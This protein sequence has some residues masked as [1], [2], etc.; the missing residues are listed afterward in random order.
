MTRRDFVTMAGAAAA[1]LAGRQ[2][3]AGRPTRP[4]IVVFFT[5]QQRWDTC[6]CYRANPMRLTPNLDRMAARGTLLRNSFTCQPVCA[7]A[8][9]SFQTGLYAT[10]HGVWRNGIPL[11]PGSPTLATR[12]KEAGYTTGYIGKWHLA[13][14]E[15]GPVPVEERGGYDYWL[16][17][18]VLE[19]T[20]HPNDFRTWTGDNKEYHRPGYR[21]DA[22][23]DCMLDFLK[24]RAQAPGQPFFLFSSFLEPHHQ[25]DMNHF[26][27]PTGYAEKYGNRM[28]VPPDLREAGKGDWPAE[29]PD[30]YGMVA[31][32]DE[33]LGRVLAELKRLGM[34]RDTVVMFTS[35]HGCHFRTRNSEYK[36]SCHEASIHVPTVF[37][38]PGFDRRRV[39]NELVS[40]PDWT[41]T[42]LDAAGVSA[43]ALPGRSILGLLDGH[44]RDWP[45]EVFIQVSESQ[46]GRAIRTARWKYGVNAPQA[47]G[48]GSK[49]YVEQ[50]LYDLE[51]D[52]YE[53]HN[54]VTDPGHRA[55][56]DELMATLKRRMVAAGEAEPVIS[57]A[58]R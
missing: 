46:T 31:R 6:G 41:S 12:L 38:G 16:A 54:L 27:A 35:D 1:G 58:V 2:A 56:A 21:V 45:R 26:V 37:Q 55:I 52:P 39:V 50:Y 44:V 15:K 49:A 14:S 3:D 57:G 20:S 36:R 30:Y 4:N 7:P 29:L 11:P 8:R 51:K 13:D 19:F 33:C 28:W 53:Q 17:S 25:N 9:G 40:I 42:L 43:P 10:Q 18:D 34:D 32:L 23:T 48:S 24:A 22:Q 47:R 5:D